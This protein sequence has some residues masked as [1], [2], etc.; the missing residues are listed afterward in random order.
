MEEEELPNISCNPVMASPSAH[1]LLRG[2]KY[3]GRT[4]TVMA[5]CTA[6]VHSTGAASSAVVKVR[7]YGS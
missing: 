3:I 5:A 7:T 1:G 6:P 4:C 2:Y